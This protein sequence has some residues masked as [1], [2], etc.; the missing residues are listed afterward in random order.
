[1][2]KVVIKL[3]LLQMPLLLASVMS[4]AQKK[5]SL[6][7]SNIDEVVVTAYGIKKEKKALGYVYQTS[8]ELML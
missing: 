5:D 1:M 4:Y 6:K 2:K 8:K 7:T 3:G